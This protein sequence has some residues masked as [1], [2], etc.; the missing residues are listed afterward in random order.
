MYKDLVP[1]HLD[2]CDVIYHLPSKIQLP[3]IGRTVNSLI[4]KAETIQYQLALAITGACQGS[5]R[6]KIYEEL[7]WES[8]F[9][10]R[11]CRRVLQI[12]KIL[13][14]NTTVSSKRQITSLKEQS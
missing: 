2:N 14:E 7:G 11:N 8:L 3:P 4:E 9:D 13:N 5:R 10:R 1:L 6:S 12:Y